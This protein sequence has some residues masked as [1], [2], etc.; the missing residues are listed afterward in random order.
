LATFLPLAEGLDDETWLYHQT[1][2]DYSKWFREGIKDEALADEVGQ[3]E[4]AAMGNE[5]EGSLG[6]RESR[7]KIKA[8]IEQRHTAPA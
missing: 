8:A 6:P 3:N 4:R 7:E 2:G 1:R 5:R